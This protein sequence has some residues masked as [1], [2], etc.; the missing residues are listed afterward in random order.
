M[1]L[2]GCAGVLLFAVGCNQQTQVDTKA[3]EQAV[4]DTDTK[5]SK[6]AATHDLAGVLSF[7]A[8]DATVLPPN[9]AMI[10]TK[11]AIHDEWAALLMSGVDLSWK[12]EKVESASS[13]DFVYETGTYA[14]QVKDANGN[15]I[16]DK[17]KVLQVWKKQA[18]GSW[19]A[20]ADMWS[21]DLPAAAAEPAPVMKKKS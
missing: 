2:C 3:A 11:Q 15:P 1:L 16:T 8:D 6:A 14:L 18:D 20:V 9:E 12:A 5:W 17:G 7:Y 19:K 21:S 4:R 13:G 10:T